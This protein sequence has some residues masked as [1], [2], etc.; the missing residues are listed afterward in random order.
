MAKVTKADEVWRLAIQRGFLI[1]S[2]EIYGGMGGFYDYGPVGCLLKNKIANLFRDFCVRKE[3]F[4]EIDGSVAV[5][6]D[7]LIA[8]GHVAG[9][10]D[11]VV[12][13]LKCKETF[14]A[15]HLIEE[16]TKRFVE[17]MTI[18]E[19]TNIIKSEKLTCPKC[20][21]EL[22]DVDKFPLM[23]KFPVGAGETTGY[24]R[25]ET[26]QSIFVDF[27]RIFKAYREKLPLGV[28]QIGRSFRN[29]ISPRQGLIR[30]REFTQMEIEI[31]LDPEQVN[32]YPLWNQLKN[33]KIRILTRE[34][35]KTGGD[36]IE[37]TAEEAVTKGI[38]INQYLAYWIAKETL[39]YQ[40]V[41]IPFN[42]FRFRHLTPEE[43]PFYSKSNFD[44]EVNLSMGWKETIGNAYRTDYDLTTH[45]KHSGKDMSVT[46]NGRKFIPHVVEPSWGLDRLFYCVL[47]HNFVEKG[48]DRDWAWMKFPKSIAPISVS[49]FPLM[50]KMGMEDKAKEIYQQFL[51]EGYDVQYDD[52]GSIGKRYARADEIGVPYCITVDPQ[53]ME[54]GTVTIRDRDTMK[55][56]R[57]NLDNLLET[58]QKL[59]HDKIK[60]EEAGKL[61]E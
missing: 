48:K 61:V 15:D 9:F 58:I 27:P 24:L 47:E 16:K 4:V 49:V 52:S 30:M 33:V 42:Q 40:M 20:G 18:Y 29:E 31:F 35:Q 13:C 59:M 38:V 12:R 45:S 32:N 43:T 6:E 55:Q 54:D 41:G 11:P 1:P 44:L 34:A 53:T 2:C 39:F 19:L 60:F 26:A 22:T 8:S 10:S 46:V 57:V 23:F 37:L 3:G 17:G 36:A 5:K 56:V 7:V 51:N 21:G 28:A 25:P 14:R 50:K